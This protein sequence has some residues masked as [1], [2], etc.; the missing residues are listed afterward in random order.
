[1]EKQLTGYIATHFFNEAGF[2]WT[3]Q[4]AKR[5]EED[6]NIKLYVPQRN[7]TINDK[8]KDEDITA[9]KIAQVDSQ[10]LVD[11]NVLI[12]CLDGVE[13]DAGVA[14]EIGFFSALQN[15]EHWLETKEGYTVMPRTIV[16][17][18]TDIR[19][20]GTGDNRFYINLYTK[21]LVEIGGHIVNST[22]ELIE[23]LM[24]IE[25]EFEILTMNGDI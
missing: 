17:I 5:I 25:T 21:G 20:N 6:V 11:S 23:Y 18:Y 12:A 4:L 22:E 24:H 2:A 1:M 3:E 10:H 15:V 7:A 13:I 8:T 14:S 19:R 9:M 16:A